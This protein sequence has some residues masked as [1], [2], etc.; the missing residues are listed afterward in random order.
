M[1]YVGK[2]GAWKMRAWC[3]LVSARRTSHVVGGVIVQ[4]QRSK[5]IMTIS[6]AGEMDIA[7]IPGAQGITDEQFVLDAV[8][9]AYHGWVE[10]HRR[11][12]EQWGRV[13]E[14]LRARA[15]EK[16][17]VEKDQR[18]PG[19]VGVEVVKAAT[20]SESQQADQAQGGRRCEI[21]EGLRWKLRSLGEWNM[22][23]E[24]LDMHAEIWA[25]VCPICRIRRGE[26]RSHDWRSCPEGAADVAAVREVR[27]GMEDALAKAEVSV[28][29]LAIVGSCPSCDMSKRMCWMAAHKPPAVALFTQCRF[30][31]VVTEGV[32]AMM[33]IGPAMVRDWEEREG[34]VM[35]DGDRYGYHAVF[36]MWK[37]FA[38]LGA[39]DIRDMSTKKFQSKYAQ[40]IGDWRASEGEYIEIIDE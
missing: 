40:R 7:A 15:K 2:K 19:T 4:Y 16:G 26:S 37:T 13:I 25:D 6:P 36:K 33:A 1:G 32:A 27:E 9:S 12:D 29:S 20:R 18:C 38:W 23:G 39:I 21:D 17:D 14:T 8:L 3:G 31:T 10:R 35:D 22:G 28:P 11:D 30:R 34:G 5:R 24:L